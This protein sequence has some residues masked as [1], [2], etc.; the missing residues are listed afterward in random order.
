MKHKRILTV[1]DISCVGQCSITVALPILSACGIETAILPTAV[2]STHTGGNW[3]PYIRDLSEDIPA[4]AAN[5][6]GAGIRFDGI[7]TG[8]LGNSAIVDRLIGMIHICKAY[9]ATLIV[10][11]AM[12]DSGKLY[13]GFDADYAKEM[14]KLCERADY[15]L[16]NVTEACILT[17]TPYREDYDSAFVEELLSKL[18]ERFQCTIILTGVNCSDGEISVEVYGENYSDRYVNRRLHR[19]YHGTGDI[20]ASVFTGSLLKGCDIMQSVQRAADFV[21]SCIEETEADPEHW[22]GVCFEP[23]LHQL[24]L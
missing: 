11:H 10:D 24:H 13:A 9:G 20:F 2:L 18:Y 19:S 4:V 5:W 1:Q 17:G 15:L 8:Y 7:Y 3:R 22:Y 6:Q 12:A 16:P 14:E 23:L 21:C